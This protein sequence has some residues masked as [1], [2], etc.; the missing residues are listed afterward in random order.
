MKPFLPLMLNAAMA[1]P[2]IAQP[3]AYVP[4]AG[5]WDL[6]VETP[7]GTYPSWMEV[8]SR[9]GVVTV[10]V[11]GREGGLH[12]SDNVRLDVVPVTTV[13]GLNESAVVMGDKTVASELSFTTLEAFG[14]NIPVRWT[15][16]SAGN[17]ITGLQKRGDGVQGRISGERAPLLKRKVPAHWTAPEPLFP[18]KGP[19]EL[20]AGASLASERKLD[21]F[22]LH[23]EVNCPKG[24]IG[25]ILLR[26]RYRLQLSYEQPPPEDQTHGMGALYGFLAPGGNLPATPGEWESFDITLAGRMLTVARNGTIVI[27]NKQIPGITGGAL[28]SHE[29]QPGPVC[30]I[31]ESPEPVKFRNITVSGPAK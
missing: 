8:S 4:Y 19:I 2:L 17:R 22:K 6:T 16:D 23:I 10:V 3:R 9:D 15:I 26:G 20:H 31:G 30:L 13:P 1:L 27:E 18:G 29:G 28:D 21:D 12:G 7:S 25:G 5:R 14:R 11:V 24:G